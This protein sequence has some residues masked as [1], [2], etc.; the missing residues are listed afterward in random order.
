MIRILVP[1]DGSLAAEESLVHAVAIAK[2]FPADLTILRVIDETEPGDAV[3]ADSVYLALWRR[4]AQ[5]YLDG[6]LERFAEESLS[7]NCIVSEGRPAETIIRFVAEAKPDLLVM[8]RYGLGNA[9]E[10]A[11]GGTA[12]KIVSRVDCSV[13]LLDPRHPIDAEQL[14]HRILVPVDDCRE[15]DCAVALACM[16]AEIHDASLLLLHVVDEPRLPTGLPTTPHAHKLVEDMNRLVRKEAEH[17]VQELAAKIP[18]GVVVNT[19]VLVSRDVSLA[20]ESTAGDE[21]CDLLLLHWIGKGAEQRHP[22]DLTC[23]SLILFSHHALFILRAS[24]TEGITSNFRSVYL[25]EPD[26]RAS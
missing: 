10:F 4:Q 24:A 1:L 3:R 5:A 11:T 6:L 21:D 23:Q 22:S 26:L 17:R 16:I 19:R 18:A 15:S 25:D 13:L 14:Y 7:A 8:T 2:V 9:Q 12:Q 20:I